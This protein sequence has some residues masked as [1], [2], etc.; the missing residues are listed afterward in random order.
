MDIMMNSDHTLHIGKQNLRSIDDLEQFVLSLCDPYGFVKS[1]QLNII[2]PE[3]LYYE[4]ALE[5][6]K[7]NFIKGGFYGNSSNR[8]N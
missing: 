4:D 7:W 2:G 3:H 8:E 1:K 6:L 5:I